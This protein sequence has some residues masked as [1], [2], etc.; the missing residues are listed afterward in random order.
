MRKLGEKERQFPFFLGIGKVKE[1][2]ESNQ[3]GSVMESAS[4]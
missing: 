3:A 4:I 2:G 1:E